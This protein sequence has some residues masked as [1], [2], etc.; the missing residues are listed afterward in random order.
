MNSVLGGNFTSRL[1][2][3]LRED[4]GWTYGASSFVSGARGPQSFG[5]AT[6]VQTDKTAE[7]LTEIGRE[8]REYRSSRPATREELD[9]MIKG[10]V[11]ALPGRL[12]T[13]NAVVGYLQYADRFDL[14][15]DY[16]ASLPGKYAALRP[17]LITA[18]AVET[19][20][21]DAL[22]WVVVG[23]LDKIEQSVRALDLGPVEVWDAEGRKVR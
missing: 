17:E 13:N 21:P 22:T 1:N 5:V 10:E 3:N 12:E 6:N 4:K 16:L 23:D 14:P 2:M 20:R 8:I 15:Y 18:A 9:L 19:L 11:L 7:A